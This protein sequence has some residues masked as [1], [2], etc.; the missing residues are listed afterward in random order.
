MT[1][2]PCADGDVARAIARVAVDDEHLV[3]VRPDRVDDLAD[4]PFFV[5]GGDDNGDT[6]RSGHGQR[7]RM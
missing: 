7:V 4:Q 1:R 3:G 2:A 5:L 6:S